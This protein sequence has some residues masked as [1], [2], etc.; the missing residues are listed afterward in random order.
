MRLAFYLSALAMI[1]LALAILLLPLVRGG[2]RAGRPG[3]LFALALVLAFLVPLAAA[4]LYL[5]VGTP[6][7]LAGVPQAEQQAPL[8]IE[9]A[10]AQLHEHL[11]QQPADL[12]GWLLLGQTQMARQQPAPAREAFARAL[13]LAPEN[14]LAGVGWA[15]A[16]SLVRAD[17]RVDG[18][19]RTLLEQAV[20][21][22]PDN[23]R[24]LWLLGISDFQ[25]GHYARA[26]QRWRQ[27][28]PLLDPG[29]AVARSVAAQIAAADARTSGSAQPAP[30][31]TSRP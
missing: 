21:Q 8:D 26:A 4:G 29:S 2:R 14:T 16:D 19:A 9:Q 6:S 27:L 13:K 12:Q 28:Q 10:L 7:T 3:S 22:Q 1:A 20:R 25:E 11:R 23:Q 18:R 15:E 30:A 24:A 5:Y 17:H 31:S